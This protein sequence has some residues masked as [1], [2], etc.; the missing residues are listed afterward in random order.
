M[1]RMDGGPVVALAGRQYNSWF[2]TAGTR[3]SPSCNRKGALP[4]PWIG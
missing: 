2:R 4:R 1:N 3:A